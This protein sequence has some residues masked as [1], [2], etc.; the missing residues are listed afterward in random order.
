MAGG[1]GCSLFF[2]SSEGDDVG[3]DH[4]RNLASRVFG[5]F[6]VLSG[7]VVILG[8]GGRELELRSA[9]LA[10]GVGDPLGDSAL[11]RTSEARC[12]NYC[13]GVVISRMGRTLLDVG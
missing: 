11:V 4:R 8:P 13:A 6:L 2:C 1:G 12:C 5:L 3:F 10:V 7:M 9:C